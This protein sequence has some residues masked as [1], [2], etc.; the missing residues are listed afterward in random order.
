MDPENSVADRLLIEAR[1]KAARA[2]SPKLGKIALIVGVTAVIVSPISVLGW[3]VGAT[4]L[5]MGYSA[6]LRPVSRKRGRIAMVLGFGAILIGVFF[7]TLVI[8]MRR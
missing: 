5:G 4:A 2:E 7:Y 6:A 1:K 3:I 8:A